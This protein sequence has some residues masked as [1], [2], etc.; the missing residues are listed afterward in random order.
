MTKLAS[1]IMLSHA[2]WWRDF[3]V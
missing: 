1:K 3:S 2:R